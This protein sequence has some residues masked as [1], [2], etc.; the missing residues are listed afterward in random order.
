[1]PERPNF[2]LLLDLDPSV[3]D[4]KVIE[5]RIQEKQRE[6]SRDRSMGSP[7]ARRKAESSL[8]QL[9]EIKAVLANVETRRKE[10]K[11][12]IRQ[13]QDRRQERSQELDDAISVLQS[14]GPSWSE[15]TIQKLAQQSAGTSTRDE[16]RQRLLVAAA[17]R[18][19]RRA[20]EM[21]DKV[22]ARNIR[23]NLDHLHLT[24]LYDFLMLKPRSSPKALVDRAD[25]IYRENQRRGKFDADAAAG[26][27]LAGICKSVFL[28]DQEKAKYD[29]YL[30]IE[31]LGKLKA[32]LELAGADNVISRSELDELLR[33]A[34]RHG[35][36]AEDAL[37]YIE[38]YASARKWHI[39]FDSGA[40]SGE[41]FRV[42]GVCSSRAPATVSRCP[43]C[44][45]L[46]DIDC[47]TCGARNSSA[48]ETCQSCGWP[49]RNAASARRLLQEDNRLAPPPA[50]DLPRGPITWFQSTPPPKVTNV[51]SKSLGICIVDPQGREVVANLIC[52]DDPVPTTST[53]CIETQED[54]LRSMTL[55]CME[56]ILNERQ[57]ALSDC[58]E[59]GQAIVEFG[60]PLPRGSMVEVAFDLGPDGLLTVRAKDVP[61]GTTVRAEFRTAAILPPE[62]LEA[63]KRRNLDQE[64]GQSKST[65]QRT[66]PEQA[67]PE[68]LNRKQPTQKRDQVFISYSHKDRI[69]LERLQVMLKPLIRQGSI[70]LWDDTK[71]THGK[72]WKQEIESALASA[73]VA[74]LLVSSNFLASDFVA[75][76][77]LPSLL[78]AAEKEGLVI[79]W[80][81]LGHCLYRE[82]ELHR[83]QAVHDPS[84]PLSSR[85]RAQWEKVLVDLG[86]RVKEAIQSA[87]SSL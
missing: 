36:S 59:I 50:K 38:D 10:A 23:L 14:G 16:V 42:C 74:I 6:W 84:R 80:L 47:Q 39:Q 3:D 78:Q 7:K 51:T 19:P 82:T 29:N 15:E 24:S 65:P 76:N 1:M 68:K 11:V 33:Q 72:P 58:R 53:L 49:L 44:G 5:Q 73:R 41:N 85:G 34:H 64:I 60:R 77:E 83:F 30:A 54:G 81:C 69:W 63:A 71:I 22:T 56:N 17:R 52:I 26:N 87:P 37:A 35:V 48:Q 45:E 66:T 9:S 32:G 28:N 70:F 20:K 31:T 18:G 75:E 62:Q 21:I 86:Q 79:L 67:L 12:A 57:V 27:T 61:T 13:Q 4:W 8:A 40:P 25:E 46:L 55:Y 43:S 2:Y